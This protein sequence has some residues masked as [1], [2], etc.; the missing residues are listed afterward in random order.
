MGWY[1]LN[2]KDKC[3]INCGVLENCDKVI[4]KCDGGC[5]VG[6]SDD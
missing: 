5:K 6:W 4:G 3:S 2:C 1:G